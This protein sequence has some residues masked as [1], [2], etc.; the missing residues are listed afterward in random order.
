M[1]KLEILDNNLALLIFEQYKKPTVNEF[2]ISGYIRWGD[3]NDYPNFIINLKEQCAE[4]GAI[5]DTKAAYLSGKG[6]YAKNEAQKEL[7][8]SF[9]MYANK[10]QSWDELFSEHLDKSLETWNRFYLEVIT[11]LTGKP[12]EFNYIPVANCRLSKCGTTLSYSE[13]W[14]NTFLYPIQTISEYQ[15][16]KVGKFFMYFD[17]EVEKASNLEKL[18]P[19]PPYQSCIIDISSDT[20]IS[21][22]NYNYIANGF[23]AGNLVTFFNGEPT[24]EEKRSIKERF[25]KTYTGTDNA[26]KTVINYTDKD[27]K[28]AEITALNVDDLDKKFEMISKRLQQKIITGHRVTN[29]ELFGITKEG[30]AL[31][32][33]QGLKESQ[34]LFLNGYTKPRQLKKCKFLTKIAYLVTGQKIE[35]EVEQLD[36]IG[37]DLLNDADLTQDERR[38]LKGYEPLVEGAVKN[39]TLDA[40]NSISPLVATKVLETMTEDEIRALASLT[41][42]NP[43]ILDVNGLPVVAETNIINESLKSL[44]GKENMNLMRILRNYGNGKT[45]KEQATVL[46]KNGFGLND[47]DINAML[48]I[49]E[50]DMQKFSKQKDSILMRFETEAQD[51][52]DED[53]VISEDF[54]HFKNNEDALMFELSKQKMFFADALSI[55]VKTLES[56][57]LNILKGNPTSTPNEISKALGV[58]VNK[59]NGG[60]SGLLGKDLISPNA[61]GFDP[62]EKA[63]DKLTKPFKNSLVY[64]V[65]KY[66][67]KSDAPPLSAG[68]KSRE[69]CTEMMKLSKTKHWKFETIKSME[70]D[71]G[72]NAWDYRGGFYNNGVET[73]PFCRHVWKAITK[74]KQS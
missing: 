34:D 60:L 51:D 22:F 70:N 7:A 52:T 72:T 8:D 11:D 16:G 6:L 35:F 73:Q 43:P 67:L 39:A 13:D 29:P 21:N 26:G 27:G 25:N 68:G 54:V 24:P 40:L 19:T 4:H 18:Y 42:K 44:S 74:V 57:I 63:F 58:D 46:L 28:A 62:T 23:S 14:S 47:S 56:A 31:S 1:A 41:P 61:N 49:E 9:L 69:F 10:R 17:Y 55:S 20:E 36:N 65:Y 37:L 12:I 33:R 2:E 71:L 3:K 32:T 59:V 66:A 38:E 64:T 15:R 5:I 45:T 53:E 48:G 50:E 30:N